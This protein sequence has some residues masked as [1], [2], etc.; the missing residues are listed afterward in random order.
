M[1]AGCDSTLTSDVPLDKV[2]ELTVSWN[3]TTLDTGA[4]VATVNTEA[5]CDCPP[6]PTA[7]PVPLPQPIRMPT[8]RTNTAAS[9]Y[10]GRVILRS[11]Y[12][13]DS[14]LRPGD[15]AAC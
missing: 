14:S 2:M 15:V 7:E 3:E 6:V 10:L 8:H 13:R 12:V 9:T 5:V 4:S 11:L 1:T